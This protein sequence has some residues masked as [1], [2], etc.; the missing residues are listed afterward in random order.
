VRIFAS[1]GRAGWDL[2]CVGRSEARSPEHSSCTLH[3]QR[4]THEYRTTRQARGWV[5]RDRR[6][7]AGSWQRPRASPS[8]LGIAPVVERAPKGSFPAKLIVE[9]VAYGPHVVRPDA[10]LP[11]ADVVQDLFGLV[12]AVEVDVPKAVGIPA[13]PP[14]PQHA[15]AVFVRRL[16]PHPTAC[17]PIRPDAFQK[18]R[19]RLFPGGLRSGG[20]CPS[21]VQTAPSVP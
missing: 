4:F 14:D 11:V 8:S 18:A 3:E 6:T 21:L 17:F 20:Q 9:R 1:V 13:I 2:P 7:I 5:L 15:V 12:T 16:T 10:K 19:Q